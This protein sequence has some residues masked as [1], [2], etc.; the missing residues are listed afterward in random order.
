MLNLWL[1]KYFPGVE[2]TRHFVPKS[3]YD[4][5][6]LINA[7]LLRSHLIFELCLEMHRKLNPGYCEAERSSPRN[8]R[9]IKHDTRGRKPK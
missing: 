5:M 7:A 8:P 3:D 1:F 2:K 9:P 4:V 6:W